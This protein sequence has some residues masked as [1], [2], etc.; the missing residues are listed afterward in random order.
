MMTIAGR[1]QRRILAAS[2]DGRRH[3]VCGWRRGVGILATA[4]TF[5]A[6]AAAAQTVT[7]ENGVD[8]ED[9]VHEIQGLIDDIQTRVDS[10]ERA[11]SGSDTALS[12]LNEQVEEAI[13]KLTSRLDENVALRGQTVGLASELQSLSADEADLQGELARITQ[14]RD[15]TIVELEQ[16]IAL[17]ADELAAGTTA[18]LSLD[19]RITFLTS[20]LE[21]NEAERNQL[22]AELATTQ[23]ARANALATVEEQDGTLQGLSLE[24]ATLQSLRDTLA[25][26]VARLAES[27]ESGRGALAQ[28]NEQTDQLRAALDRSQTA[29]AATQKRALDTA[30]TLRLS[31]EELLEERSRALTLSERLTLSLG[32]LSS[33][34]SAAEDIAAQLAAAKKQNIAAL[35]KKQREL[36]ALLKQAKTSEASLVREQSARDSARERVSLLTDQLRELKQQLQALNTFLEVSEAKNSEQRAQIVDLGSRLNQALATRVQELANYRSEFFGRLREVLGTRSDVRVVGD[37]FVFQSEVLFA[38]GEATLGHDGAEQLQRLGQTLA[39]ISKTIPADV[40]WVLRVDGHTDERPISTEAFPSNWELSAA[41]AL[42]VVKFLI[43]SGIPPNRLVAAGFGQFHPLD[44]RRDEIGFRRNRRI[45][46]K[47]TQR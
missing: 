30:E 21:D 23:E 28:E 15:G 27:V 45:E 31:R 19:N 20:E 40:D 13:A 14:E 7:G 9:P 42:S 1:P 46:F 18:R 37:R 25:E 5:W 8:P 34:K 36:E 3:G 22:S 41:R 16:Q 26:Q 44:S 2:P 35:A 10:I 33:T 43:D 4:L 29:L 38:S 11:A 6:A 32:E 17:L 24:V 12:L 47:L 39:E